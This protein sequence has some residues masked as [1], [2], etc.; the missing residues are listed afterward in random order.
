MEFPHLSDTKFPHLNNINVYKYQN[1]FDYA[2]WTGKVSFKLLNVLWN[3]NYNDVPYFDNIEH[4]DAWFDS[5]DGYVGTL[6][7]LFN[8][9]PDN[10]IKVPIP[11]NDAYNY[12]YL[13]VDMPVQTSADNPINYEDESIRIKRWFYFIEDISQFA[14][15]ATELQISVDYWT[16]F[17]HSVSIPY[18]MLERGHAPMMQTSV[19]DYLKNP[20]ENSEYLLADD[21][22]YGDDSIVKNVKYVPMGNGKKYVCFCAPYNENDFNKFGAVE[23]SGSSTGPTFEDTSARWGYQMQVNN[24][25]W[26]Y[27]YSDYSNARMPIT[28]EIQTGILNGCD[29]YAIE[30]IQAKAFFNECATYC[31]QFIHGIQAMFMIDESLFDVAT[32]FKFR[33]Y[34]LHAINRKH[35]VR[36]VTFEKSQFNFDSKYEDITKLYTFPY[37]SIEVTD[38][39]GQ[40]FVAKIENCGRVQ[41]RSEVSFMYPY[42]DYNMF[43]TGINGNGT[44]AKYVWETVYG[45]EHNREIWADDFSK[46]MMNWD[47]P[48]YAIYISS[49]AEF[50]ANNAGTMQSLR[51]GAILDYENAVRYANTVYEN[52]LDTSEMKNDNVAIENT[53]RSNTT[54]ASNNARTADTNAHNSMLNSTTSQNNQ[55][56][57]DDC[58]ADNQMVVVKTA[59]ENEQAALAGAA[60]TGAGIVAGVGM[61]A[62]GGALGIAVG[63]GTLAAAAATSASTIAGIAN[64][65]TEAGAII[66]ANTGK[67]VRAV[68]ANTNINSY[69]TA[70]N[71]AIAGNDNAR[72]SAIAGYLNS[73]DTSTMENET[74]TENN[75]AYYT[76]FAAV[77]AAKFTL[78]QRQKEAEAN[79]KNTRL[80]KPTQQGGYGGDYNP[81][82]FMRRGVSINV[83]TQNDSA[84]A[85]AGD[86]FLRFGYALHRVWDMTK[87]FHYGKNFTFWKAEDI[88]INDG[89]GTANIATTTIGSILLKGV[90]IWR[91]PEKIGKV[92]IYSNI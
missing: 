21:F 73:S 18:L 4:R 46:F 79:Y 10:K 70:S 51:S 72:D 91:D 55:K 81:D 61:M 47:I 6:E 19:E 27:G 22:N 20:I 44:S 66:L 37:S 57:V 24:Y 13:V 31:V 38:N 2:R 25:Q 63:I 54:S 69:T 85:Q 89:T 58:S 68:G 8:S 41:M 45:S 30:G 23:Y 9:T 87:G 88:W 33:G 26:K 83:R 86:A 3:S 75:N 14:P 71:S 16:T 7:S 92:D 36:D 60:N 28:N 74:D 56:A 42:L 67:A 50:S 48:V 5:Q 80:Q 49:E 15:N 40:S 11:Y 35:I 62:A 64:N 65:S 76:R 77:N 52:T 53:A 17:I 82:V 59:L 84:I 43:F 32:T 34:T 78:I 39:N 12:N 29:C 1:N 90:T